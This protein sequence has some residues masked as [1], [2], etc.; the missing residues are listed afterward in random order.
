MKQFAIQYNFV[1]DDDKKSDYGRTVKYLIEFN[2]QNLSYCC[3]KPEGPEWSK[4]EFNRCQN[5]TL[6]KEEH[7]YC[8]V[9]KNLSEL[10]DEFNEVN[11]FQK[12]KVYVQTPERIYSKNTDVQTGLLSCFGAIMA[13]SGCPHLDIFRPLVKF[14]LPFSTF[15]ETIYRVVSMFLLKQC[16]GNLD[17]KINFKEMMEV[18]KEKYAQVEIVNQGMLER[19]NKVVKKDADKNAFVALNSFAQIFSM[20][21]DTNFVDTLAQVFKF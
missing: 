12:A 14:H 2:D 18:L 6:K 17:S 8:P 9:A 10:I 5:C 4:L 19:I 11:S 3:K 13:A 16:Y 20:E 21:C 7:N 15:E 1:F